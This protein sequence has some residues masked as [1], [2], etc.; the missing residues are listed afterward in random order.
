MKHRISKPCLATK[1][2]GMEFQE[3]GMKELCSC[4]KSLIS[5]RFYGFGMDNAKEVTTPLAQHFKLSSSQ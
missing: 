3:T 2:L 1:I 4:H 5:T